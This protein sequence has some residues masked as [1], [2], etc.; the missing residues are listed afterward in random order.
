MYFTWKGEE[1]SGV[2]ISGDIRLIE[3]VWGWY[4]RPAS[5]YVFCFAKVLTFYFIDFL[6]AICTWFSYIYLWLIIMHSGIVGYKIRYLMFVADQAKV[7]AI[8]FSF[9]SIQWYPRDAYS[10]HNFFRIP[11]IMLLVLQNFFLEHLKLSLR[12]THDHWKHV[13]VII[14]EVIMR[15]FRTFTSY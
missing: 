2:R 5:R 11:Q 15:I 4:N 7:H 9:V 3:E 12:F 1:R 14:L 8:I 10:S 13:F 6:C